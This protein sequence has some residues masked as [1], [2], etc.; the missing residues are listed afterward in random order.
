MQL[1]TLEE[2][3]RLLPQVAAVAGQ[4]RDAFVELRALQAS[5][6]AEERSASGDGHLLADPWKGGG[7]NR[8]ESLNRLL[9]GAAARLER[10]GIELKDPEK[11]LLDF[12]SRREGEVV[13]L[14]W[15]LGEED[16]R[17]WH[18]IAGGFAGRQPL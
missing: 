15:M 2:A 7:E 1:Y 11:G 8:V 17:Y 3:R 13:F 14:C 9:R 12:Y 4:L 5:F 6:A 18:T 10:W 16:I